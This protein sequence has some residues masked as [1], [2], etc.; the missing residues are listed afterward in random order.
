MIYEQKLKEAKK[1]YDKLCKKLKK[2]KSSYEIECLR[3][4]AEDAR[5]D[6]IELQILVN[7]QKQ[8]KK[9]HECDPA[10]FVY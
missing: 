6:V 9:L 4:D 7:E 10:Q 2:A 1:N 8:N 3:E 5:Q